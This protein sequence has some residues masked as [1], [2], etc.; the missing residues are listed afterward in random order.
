MARSVTKPVDLVL[1]GG[2]VKGIGLAG[3]VVRL[4]EAGYRAHRVAGSSA[5]SIVGSIVA[6][7]ATN[8]QLTPTTSGISP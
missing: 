6:A 7:A 8:D 5:G 3:A 2:G 1:A 4:M